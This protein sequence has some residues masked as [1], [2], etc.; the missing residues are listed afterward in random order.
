MTATIDLVSSG[1]LSS[2]RCR[3]DSLRL[4]KGAKGT[5]A[6]TKKS[7]YNVEGSYK[8]RRIRLN[9]PRSPSHPRKA[10]PNMPTATQPMP[11]ANATV[12]S[13]RTDFDRLSL[14]HSPPVHEYAISPVAG[15][16]FPSSASPASPSHHPQTRERRRTSTAPL[17]KLMTP[18][19]STTPKV[20]LLENVN[21]TAVQMLKGQ[22]YIVDEVKKA[23]GE[24]DLIA[25]LKEGGYTALGIRSKTKI[26]QRVIRE[27]GEKVRPLLLALPDI[28]SRRVTQLLVIGCFCIGTNQ[29]DLLAAAKAGISVFNSPFSNSR[30]VAELVISEVIALSRQLCDRSTELHNGIWNK[31]SAGCWEV[32][33]KTLGI[34]GYGH[35]GAQLSVLAEAM[36]MTVIYADVLPIMPLGSAR[37]T[38]TLNDLLAQADFVTLHVPELPETINMISSAELAAM[39]PGSYLI[40][41]ARGKVVDIPAL[42]SALESKH[43][44]GAAIDVFPHEPASNGPNFDDSC[45]AWT[46]QLRKLPNL[47]LTP[48]IGGSTEEAQRAI[49]A[50]VGAA[51]IRYVNFGASIGAV[52]FPEVSLRPILEEGVVR[53]CHVHLNQPGVLRTINNIVGDYNVE[54]QYSDSKGDIAYV[55]ADIVG[56]TEKDISRLYDRIMATTSNIAT[57]ILF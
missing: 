50:E 8:T 31:V 27:A 37:Q 49:G 12:S 9:P 46:S 52:N 7:Q 28:R 24:Q 16:G 38:D 22:G 6:A 57:R 33:G 53:V 45:N 13:P 3:V 51:L 44:A 5:R 29:V 2:L 48:H 1:F 14:S 18:F 42:I 10:S 54:K 47:I 56:I 35:I 19:A 21:Q 55:M 32:R 11:I 20:L 30:S 40:N 26:T 15:N 43:L 23:L 25:R 4:E 39:K 17:P 36:G 34:V 41:N